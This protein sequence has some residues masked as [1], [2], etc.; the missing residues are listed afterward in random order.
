[1]SPTDLQAFFSKAAAY[2]RDPRF[3]PAEVG[4]KLRF[5]G[6]LRQ[7]MQAYQT[8][9]TNA[10]RQLAVALRSPNQNMIDWRVVQPLLAW[11]ALR[12]SNAP[13]ALKQLWFGGGLID[14]RFR[15]FA[16][17]LSAAGITRPGAQLS[18][19]STLLMGLSA[20]EYP[21]IR[22]WRFDVA[23]GEAGYPPFQRDQDAAARYGHA[24]RFLDF[25]IE[26]AP[27]HGVQLQHRLEAQGV[28]WCLGGGWKGY[29]EFGDLTIAAPEDDEIDDAEAAR[30][31]ENAAQGRELTE[32]E[33]MTLV[34]SRRGQGQFRN[35]LISL[36]GRCAITGC[37]DVRLL[38]ASHLKPWKKSSNAQRL[39]P[40]NGL[41]LAPH[42]DI[43]LD[44]GL[45]TFTDDG[46]IQFSSNLS[47]ADCRCLGIGR[48]MKLSY[49]DRRH[50]EYLRFHRRYVFKN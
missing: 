19:T 16:G 17:E 4:Y 21:P 30:L 45:I 40:F 12:A 41:L 25:L 42:L 33:K 14:E 9:D 50:R 27:N 31:V 18:I 2:L 46:R 34:L 13:K 24:L 37:R 29:V 43:A 48:S 10:L 5:Q 32:T 38:R 39:D 20:K 7:A 36:W 6:E 49:V 26:Q 15:R 8:G 3:Q 1:M 23:F 44:C 22:T 11:C 47:S 28:V 35:D